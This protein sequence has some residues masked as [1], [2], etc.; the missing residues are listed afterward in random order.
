MEALGCVEGMK[1]SHAA[2]CASSGERDVTLCESVS[3]EHKFEECIAIG[4]AAYG[5]EMPPLDEFLE[6]K[7]GPEGTKAFE[8]PKPQL[9]PEAACRAKKKELMDQCLPGCTADT[10]LVGEEFDRCLDDCARASSGEPM[11]LCSGLAQEQDTAQTPPNTVNDKASGD[12]APGDGDAPASGEPAEE[13]GLAPSSSAG[14]TSGEPKIQGAI[15]RSDIERVIQ[16]HRKPITKCYEIGKEENP[17]L[18]GQVVVNFVITSAG[19]VGSS[20]VQQTSLEDRSVPNCMAKTVKRWRFPKPKG[21][22][23]AIVTLPFTLIP[24]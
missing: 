7:C 6:R 15:E 14:V 9:S 5:A 19:K 12:I 8:W 1:A 16:R 20:V 2:G 13:T 18:A 3:D 24:G 11:P 10:S 23:N 4:Y 17:K 22:G 21:G